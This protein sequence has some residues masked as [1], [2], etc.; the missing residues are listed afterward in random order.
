TVAVRD[1]RQIG[2]LSGGQRRRAFV[3]RGIAQEAEVILLDEPFAG[4]DAASQRDVSALLRELADEGRCILIATH[5]LPSVPALC[6]TVTMLHRSVV[7]HG[8]PAEVLTPEIL[9]RTFGM[10]PTVPDVPAGPDVPADPDEPADPDVPAGPADPTPA[11][12]PRTATPTVPPT[13]EETP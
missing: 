8:A 11:P 7:A 12:H 10:D 9:V 2:R 5:D 4:V 3:A 13:P 6:D 1:D